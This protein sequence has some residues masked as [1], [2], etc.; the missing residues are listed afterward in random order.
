M[1]Q[2]AS[3]ESCL[4]K[5]VN[6]EIQF[7]QSAIP[8]TIPQE[9]SLSLFRVL[10]EA[11]QNAVEYSG[12]TPNGIEL[13]VSDEGKGFDQRDAFS[14]HGLGL[15]SMRERIQMVNGVFNIKTHPGVGTT[16]SARVPLTKPEYRAMA[17]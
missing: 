12:G 16:V 15:T 6:V 11:L 2:R 17:G 14:R 1:P 9:V 13:T 10:Q 7:T 3:A 4:T 5:Q 8:A